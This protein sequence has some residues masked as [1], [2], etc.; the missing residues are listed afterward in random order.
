LTAVR[1]WIQLP[2]QVRIVEV[3]V[4]RLVAFLAERSNHACLVD[5]ADL[6]DA[7]R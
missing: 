3:F 6:F 1:H 4:G 2:F 5:V 7:V